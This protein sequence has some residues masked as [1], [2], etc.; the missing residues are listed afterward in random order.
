MTPNIRKWDA[1]TGYHKLSSQDKGLKRDLAL[2]KAYRNLI[3]EDVVSD[4]GKPETFAEYKNEA[5]KRCKQ[6]VKS[7]IKRINYVV[8]AGQ[9]HPKREFIIDTGASMHMCCD[10]MLTQAEKKTRRPLPETYT[11][12]TCN[13]R[14]LVDPEAQVHV[15]DLGVI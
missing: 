12:I 6:F 14:V 11:I 1:K 13:G 9:Y 4:T 2:H 3:D 15:P 10:M 7:I 8:S 5:S